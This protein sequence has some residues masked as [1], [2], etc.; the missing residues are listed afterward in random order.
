MKANSAALL[1]L[2]AALCVN[3]A[4]AAELDGGALYAGNCLECH[5]AGGGGVPFMQ[6]PLK[7]SARVL[8]DQDVL[9]DFVLWGTAGREGWYSEYQN[10]MPSFAQLSD[11]EL[12]AVLSYVRSSFGNDASAIDA[13][14]VAAE[15]ARKK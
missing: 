8:G 13:E 7:G 10:A 4:Q 14:S 9:I 1:G 5:M 12:A 6:P 2:V 15:R 11:D 3:P